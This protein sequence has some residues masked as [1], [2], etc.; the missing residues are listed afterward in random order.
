MLFRSPIDELF[1]FKYGKLPYRSLDIR[2]NHYDSDSFLPA[3]GISYP[4]AIGDV[5]ETEYRKMM[6]DTSGIQ[7]STVSTEYPL[8]YCRESD[9]G[10][11]PY[12]PVITKESLEIYH[13]YEVESRRYGNIFLCGRLAEFRYIDIHT[14]V[15]HALEYFENIKT[16]LT[17]V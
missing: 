12:Y 5:R 9:I 16:Y 2:W 10:N 6:F 11:E 8:E 13:Q 3:E 14:C 15:E 4:Q 7:G 17:R 1:Q